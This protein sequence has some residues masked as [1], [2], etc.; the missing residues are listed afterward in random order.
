[1]EAIMQE[2]KETG[3]SRKNIAIRLL[4][5]V[6][7]LVIFEVIKL[8]VQIAVVFQYIYLLITLSYNDSV[9]SFSNKVSTYTY[10]VMR[11]LTLNQNQRPFPLNDFPAEIDEPV[12]HVSFR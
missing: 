1:M 2:K 7:Y 3:L 5:T 4:Y 12:E 8:I 10:E 6:L 11:Y 9:R